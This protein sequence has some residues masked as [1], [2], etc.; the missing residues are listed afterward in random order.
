MEIR[1]E[2]Y[3][4]EDEIKD[5]VKD[6]F[7]YAVREKFRT[8]KDIERILTNLSY[9]FLF[10]EIDK[11]IG[12]DSFEY[13]KHKVSELLDDDSHI[14]YSIW[15]EADAWGGKES[16]AVAVM[17]QAIQ[18]NKQKIEDKVSMFVESYDFKDV[19]EE[20]FDILCSALEK[21]LLG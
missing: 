10:Q 5:I 19:K 20:I 11:A 4:S 1:I 9:E 21:R 13:I 17:K 14:R 12:R 16:P 8:E 6:Q 3:L 15:R 2:D 7:A 18:D